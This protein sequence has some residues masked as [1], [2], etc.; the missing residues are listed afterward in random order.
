LEN[1]LSDSKS[2]DSRY[3]INWELPSI[4]YQV[5]FALS[6]LKDEFT[7]YDLHTNNVMYIQTNK[8][9]ISRF[10]YMEQKILAQ[11]KALADCS[12]AEMYVFWNEAKKMEH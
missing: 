12:L 6:V 4:L 10:N 1:A 9:F 8:K 5:Y 2:A 7:H 11:G 3:T